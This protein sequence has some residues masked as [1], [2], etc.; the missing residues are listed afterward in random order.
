MA[1]TA[2]A[3]SEVRGVS[4]TSAGAAVWS[5]IQPFV[6]PVLSLL[7]GV[8]MTFQPLR[9]NCCDRERDTAARRP[10]SGVPSRFVQQ[11]LI[12]RP[13]RID[14][15]LVGILILKSIPEGTA[16]YLCPRNAAF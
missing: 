13:N 16:Q 7:P 5:M 4:T 3:V 15:G 1:A 6:M 9:I 12:C 8:L 14:S 10:A 11:A 2:I